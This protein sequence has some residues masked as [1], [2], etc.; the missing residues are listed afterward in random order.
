MSTNKSIVKS[1]GIIGLATLVSRI[2]GFVRDIL[3]A[4]LFGTTGT[5]EAFVVAFRIPN[6]LRDLMGEGAMNAAFVPVFSEYHVKK[7]PQDFWTL[8]NNVLKIIFILLGVT[9]ILGIIFAP[10]IVRIIAPGFTNTPDKLTL[11]IKLTR[12]MFPHLVLIGLSIFCMGLLNTFNSF[13]LPAL[14]PVMLNLGLIAGAVLCVHM[15][16]PVLGLAYA[17]LVG[18]FLQLVIQI[19]AIFKKGFYFTKSSHL[20]PG[21]KK[22][23]RLL[24]PRTLGSAVYQL[25]VFVDTLMASLSNIV[26]LG[27]IAAIYYANRLIQFPLAI[28][29][30]AL[31][32]AAL[33]TMS[34]FAAVGDLENLKNTV[35]FS[36]RAILLIMLP[37]SVGL[38]ILAKPI[39]KVLFERGEFSSYSTVITSSVLIFYSVGLLFFSGVKI[40]VASFYSLQDT[41]TPVKIAGICLCVNVILNFILMWPLKVGGLALASSIS[42]GLNFSILFFMLRKRIGHFLDKTVLKT[43]FQALMASCLMAVAIISF[44]HFIHLHE[45]FKLSLTILLGIIIYIWIC[46]LIDLKDMTKLLKW[47]LRKK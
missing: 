5:M 13:A 3:I 30:I 10:F 29:G 44:W 22:I 15:Q 31:S 6:L 21:T 43:V 34:K 9:T 25:N 41:T 17:V 47:I 28:F 16:E 45:I 42:A 4:A 20:Q 46:I 12:I 27:G 39:I 11:A 18:G 14:G 1:A 24:L 19:P 2:L 33:P 40:L 36:L 8:V 26:G 32:S 37:C 23:G 35:N 7:S 38:I